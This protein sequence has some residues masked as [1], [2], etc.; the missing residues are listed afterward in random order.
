MQ[1][2]H[3][4]RQTTDNISSEHRVVRLPHSVDSSHCVRISKTWSTHRKAFNEKQE[5]ER[6]QEAEE[7][8]EEQE[9]NQEE[10]EE[11]KEEDDE[12]ED[13]EEEDEEENAVKV[14][15]QRELGQARNRMKRTVCLPMLS[16]S[17]QHSKRQTEIGTT[18][19]KEHKSIT[20]A[21]G[22]TGFNTGCAICVAHTASRIPSGMQILH[23]RFV[24][25]DLF[26]NIRP[27]ITLRYVSVIY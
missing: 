7:E 22:G 13:A 26:T 23:T 24:W 2:G 25:L 11:E 18:L 15:T 9:R 1:T 10:A 17:V 16:Q 14:T 3:P 5:Q 12:D 19:R 20:N 8:K 6:N 4:G 21:T 27:I